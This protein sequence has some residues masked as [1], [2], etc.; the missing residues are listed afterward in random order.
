VQAN[1]EQVKLDAVRERVVHS[2]WT[3]VGRR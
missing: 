1:F 3:C 2:G